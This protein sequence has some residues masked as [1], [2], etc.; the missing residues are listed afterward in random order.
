MKKD[1][2]DSTRRRFLILSS[3]A[4]L[5]GLMPKRSYANII[6]EMEGEVWVNQALATQETLIKPGDMIKTGAKSRIIFVMGEDVYKLGARS[7]LQLNSNNDENSF[8]KTMRLVT[9]TLMG[10]FSK[11]EKKIEVPTAAIGIRGTGLFLK[12]ESNSTYFCTCYGETEIVTTGLTPHH[13]PVAT[14]Y[15]KAY[16]ISHD[17]NNPLLTA[18]QL[19][20]HQDKELYHLESL[21]GRKPPIGFK[22]K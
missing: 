12:I 3:S 20:D 2:F 17:S 9:G 13:Q 1:Q 14:V 19:R 7:I 10:V 8:A 11:G 18:D 21:I 22:S 15:H 6:R 4:T 5:L 16:S